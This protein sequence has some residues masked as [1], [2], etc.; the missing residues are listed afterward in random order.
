MHVLIFKYL[1]IRA[2]DS[3]QSC[4]YSLLLLIILVHRGG[5]C[6]LASHVDRVCLI[7]SEYQLLVVSY[8]SY[9]HAVKVEK[10]EKEVA[11]QFD[12]ALLLVL[13][14]SAE[15]LGGV[16]QV[17]VGVDLVGVE[18]KQRSVEEERPPVAVDQEQ[19]RQERLD[20]GLRKDILFH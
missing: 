5:Q 14:E 12:E 15:D 13:T 18:G 2:L 9:N 4:I 16:Q 8:Q 20:G 19:K 3:N 7:E 1:R 11:A 6:L 17:R 10:E